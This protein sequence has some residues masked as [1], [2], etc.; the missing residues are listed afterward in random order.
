MGELWWGL[1]RTLTVLD[2]LAAEPGRL[3]EGEAPDVLR[4]LQYRLHV[5][6]ERVY[7]L[8]PPQGTEAAHRELWAALTG[9]R[10]ATA[11]VADALEEDGREA[12]ELLVHE[13]RGALFRVR[14]ARLRLVG[15]RPMAPPAAV[16]EPR[17]A[18]A[19]ILA[20]VLVCAGAVAFV[21]GAASGHWPLWAA[22][23]L[24]VCGSALSYRP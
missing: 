1:A 21:L 9:A 10:D 7:G 19:P 18:W 15:P 3:D 14:L 6:G 24:A 5:V 17:D 2:R 12:A 4:R 13:W 8:A 20:C 16:Q 22:G 11:E 23:M